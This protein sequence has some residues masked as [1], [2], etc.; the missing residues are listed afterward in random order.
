LFG[1]LVKFKKLSDADPT[2]TYLNTVQ[3]YLPVLTI[4]GETTDNEYD[5]YETEKRQT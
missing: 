3:S 1:D 5:S 2:L 4:M